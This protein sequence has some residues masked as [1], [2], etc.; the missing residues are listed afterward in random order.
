MGDVKRARI[1]RSNDGVVSQFVTKPSGEGK[2]TQTDEG[3]RKLR[4]AAFYKAKRDGLYASI[5]RTSRAEG[6]EGKQEI[7]GGWGRATTMARENDIRKG[8][9]IY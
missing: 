6:E 4:L 5:L 1:G 9:E 8:R 7:K 3:E 2:S